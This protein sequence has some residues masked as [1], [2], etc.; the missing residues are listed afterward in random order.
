M[1]S[2]QLFRAQVIRMVPCVRELGAFAPGTEGR[3]R[4]RFPDS[5]I[6]HRDFPSPTLFRKKKK[7]KVWRPGDSHAAS[8]LFPLH[9]L[10][11]PCKATC[12]HQLCT[13][14]SPSLGVLVVGVVGQ[15]QWLSA[16][17]LR[18]HSNG[19]L[20]TETDLGPEAFNS[21]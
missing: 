5:V 17:D 12:L 14:D 21:M 15:E 13:A 2:S 4:S 18:L 10:S 8:L 16:V 20:V 19:S 6:I 9:F 11:K 7:H 3:W 1:E